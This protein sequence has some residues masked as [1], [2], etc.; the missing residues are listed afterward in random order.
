M[1]RAIALSGLGLAT[2]SPNP[3]VGCVI[4]DATGRVVGEG[5]HERKGEPHA[6]LNALVAAGEHAK[7]GTA[8]V[9]LEPCCHHGR[10]PACHQ[11]LID[12]GVERV[13]VA[14]LDPTSRE[15]G[16]ATLLQRAG[17]AV[18][19]GILADE[20][21]LVLGPWLDA[22]ESGRP[23]VTWTYQISPSGLTPASDAFLATIRPAFD[24]VFTGNGTLK[25]GVSGAHG[26]EAFSLPFV[27]PA[28]GPGELLE[29]LYAGGSR[30]VLLH[31][32]HAIAQPFLT[33]DAVDEVLLT[34]A[35]SAP[36]DRDGFMPDLPLLPPG[37]H[38]E[39]VQKLATAAILVRARPS[40]AAA[41]ASAAS[42]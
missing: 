38:I 34:F 30:S 22:M 24:A 36:R 41:A 23:R 18:E 5:Y 31:G 4:L 39:H 14:V 25:E 26:R 40:H 7:Q 35:S 21:L 29:A 8:A 15:E 16:G 10:T 2:T 37:F 28:I 42:S 32:T 12:A 33:T 19:V 11:A 17:V 9:T 20:A 27:D 3:P 1:R 13:V 6:E